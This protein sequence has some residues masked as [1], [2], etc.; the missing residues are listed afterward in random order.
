MYNGNVVQ[1]EH[2]WRVSHLGQYLKYTGHTPHLNVQLVCCQ[3]VPPHTER[4]F[5]SNWREYSSHLTT[6]IMAGHPLMWEL[7]IIK[8]TGI[9]YLATTIVALHAIATCLGLNIYQL[10][11]SQVH[12]DFLRGLLFLRVF[13]GLLLLTEGLKVESPTV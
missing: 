13:I 6:N 10:P 7:A 5:L 1:W 9:K 3:E 8:E 4:K 11:I 2:I 12:A